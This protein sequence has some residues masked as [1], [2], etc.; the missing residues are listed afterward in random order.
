MASARDLLLERFQWV[1]GHADIWPVFWHGEAFRAIVEFL[2]APFRS[3]SI[4]AVCGVESRGFLLGGAAALQLGVGFVPVRKACGLFPG[5]KLVRETQPDYRGVRHSLRLQR[6]S[7][8]EGD[9]VLLVD[10]WIETGSQALTVRDLLSDVGAELA[11]CAVVVDQT[12]PGSGHALG[13]FHAVVTSEEL[14]RSS[15]MSR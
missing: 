10:D 1:D 8:A 12:H 3:A 5:E 7:V 2:V 14:T 9:R 6:A 15:R 4:T 11:G 13:Q